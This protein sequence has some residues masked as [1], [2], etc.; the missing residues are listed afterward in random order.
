MILFYGTGFS[1]TFSKC[2]YFVAYQYEKIVPLHSL[3]IASGVY[4]KTC[5]LASAAKNY[6]QTAYAG[7]QKSHQHEWVFL[8]RVMPDIGEHFQSVEDTISNDFLPAMF[9]ESSFEEDD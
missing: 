9:G 8:Q 2:D 5:L 7:L 6:P 3:G 4:N 1:H